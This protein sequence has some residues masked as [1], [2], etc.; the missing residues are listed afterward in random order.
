MSIVPYD[1]GRQCTTIDLLTQSSR[2]KRRFN[3]D[4]MGCRTN[5]ILKRPFSII[6]GGLICH[7]KSEL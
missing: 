5:C 1:D 6:F 2:H 4:I 3:T 7:G